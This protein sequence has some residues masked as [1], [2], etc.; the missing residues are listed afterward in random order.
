MESKE[1][2]SVEG[3]HCPP[4]R[5][6]VGQNGRIGFTSAASLLNGPHVMPEAT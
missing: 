5:G 4:F 2:A 3:D 6:G 1:I